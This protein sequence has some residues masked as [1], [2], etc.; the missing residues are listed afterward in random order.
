MQDAYQIKTKLQTS[1]E[2][3]EYRSTHEGAIVTPR[4][5]Q[6]LTS[7]R[8]YPQFEAAHCRVGQSMCA[9]AAAISP[10]DT[11]PPLRRLQS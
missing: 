3:P 2:A 8:G 11:R 6:C 4:L 10:A 7:K 5:F 9:A 1:L